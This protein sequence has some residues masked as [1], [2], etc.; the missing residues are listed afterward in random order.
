M[1]NKYYKYFSNNILRLDRILILF[2]T[3]FGNFNN[4]VN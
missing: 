1:Y 4:G 2:N 3:A